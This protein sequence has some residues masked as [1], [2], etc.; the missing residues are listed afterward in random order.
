MGQRAAQFRSIQK[1]LLARFKDKTPTPLTN[2]D[3]LLEGTCRQ[4][5]QSIEA[6]DQCLLELK[7]SSN[8][9]SCIT[10]LLV[11]LVRLSSGLSEDEVNKVRAALTPNVHD[12]QEQVCTNSLFRNSGCVMK[13]IV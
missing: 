6:V 4:L 5:H 2:L 11:F 3:T 13:L 7:R 1:R 10:S 8:N 9:L 12:F